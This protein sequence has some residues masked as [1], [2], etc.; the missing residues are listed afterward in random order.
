MGKTTL[1][2]NAGPRDGERLYR[3]AAEVFGLPE[4]HVLLAAAQ[5][6]STGD[7]EPEA[8]SALRLVLLPGACMVQAL[9]DGK[10]RGAMV[11][12]NGSATVLVKADDPRRLVELFNELVQVLQALP[13]D[14]VV[15]V[16]GTPSDAVIP[17]TAAKLI[18]ILGDV[19]R[20]A[21]SKVGQREG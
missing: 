20:D 16:H 6:G 2:V 21:S 14:T 5:S 18:E 3:A 10:A 8:F 17:A 9:R 12:A 13:G 1:A 7:F 19:I 15:Q 11:D 4:W